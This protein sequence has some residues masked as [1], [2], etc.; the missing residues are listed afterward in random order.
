ML[1]QQEVVFALEKDIP[2]IDIRPPDEFNAGHI[3]RR[4]ESS[5]S[6]LH[7]HCHLGP[8]ECCAHH[9]IFI[10]I[11]VS[12]PDAGLSTYPCTGL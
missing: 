2:I 10:I 6:V 8:C 7:M 1:S 3:K 9:G 4:V 11:H 12:V 5:C